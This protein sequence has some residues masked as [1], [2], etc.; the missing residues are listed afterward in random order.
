MSTATQQVSTL[1]DNA[2]RLDAPSFNSFYQEMLR[3]HQQRGADKFAIE[4]NRLLTQIRAG[5][6]IRLWK[7]WHLLIARRDAGI[8]TENE[9]TA[10]D[11]VCETIEK[12]ELRRLQNLTKLAD[13]RKMSLPEVVQFYK[14][15]PANYA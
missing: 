12:H 1:L 4:E 2:R 9:K 11:Q 10:L 15:A 3:L 13:L 7:R 14:I 5:L 6:P 8:L